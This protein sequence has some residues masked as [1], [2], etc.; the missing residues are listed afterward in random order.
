MTSSHS[1]I[2]YL[3]RARQ[4]YGCTRRGRPS[5]RWGTA[6]RVVDVNRVDLFQPWCQT[7][8]EA[9]EAARRCGITIMGELS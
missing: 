2:G 3:M 7:K 6:W 8:P 4:E 1:K 5:Y 9:R